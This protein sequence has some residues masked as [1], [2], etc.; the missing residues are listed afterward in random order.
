MD[1]LIGQLLDSIPAGV[2]EN[3]YVIS[4]GD[5]GT[6]KWADLPAPRDPTRVKMTVYEGG[7]N[8]PLIVTGSGISGGRVERPLLAID[9][10]SMAPYLFE[11][12]L[13]SVNLFLRVLTVMSALRYGSQSPLHSPSCSLVSRRWF[14]SAVATLFRMVL[15]W[16]CTR[17]ELARLPQLSDLH[18]VQRPKSNQIS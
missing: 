15:E 2:L 3:T 8:V 6:D 1:T 16:K 18:P 14:F 9:S 7:I 13:P 10:V 5:N 12:G 17:M 4:Q 11:D